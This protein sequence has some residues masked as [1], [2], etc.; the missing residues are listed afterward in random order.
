MKILGVALSLVLLVASFV[1]GGWLSNRRNAE[2]IAAAQH[3]V[4]SLRALRAAD[5]VARVAIQ[6]SLAELALVEARQARELEAARVRWRRAAERADSAMAELDL[7]GIDA[8]SADELRVALVL[9]TDARA[10]AEQRADRAEAQLATVANERDLERENVARLT[11]ML[12][13]A[14]AEAAR[15]EKT[16]KDLASPRWTFR[17]GFTVGGIATAVVAL[18]AVLAFN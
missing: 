13:S 15:W 5:S 14:D 2:K 16:A 11:S 9:Q 8:A 12:A 1:G 17:D 6:D 4:D 7:V 18:A 10:S 3:D